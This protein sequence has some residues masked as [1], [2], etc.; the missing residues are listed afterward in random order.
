[1]SVALT[2]AADVCVIGGGPAGS[3]VARQLAVLGYDVCLLERE[4]MPRKRIG[5]SLPPSILPLLEVIGVRDQVENAGFLRPRR[6]IVWWSHPHPTV[7]RPPGPPGFHVDRGEL[8]HLLLRNT[9]TSGVTVL[10]RA[11]AMPPLRL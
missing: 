11:Q 10:Q 7:R 8:Y 9:E 4:V 3:T 6:T 2:F 5:A 1:M